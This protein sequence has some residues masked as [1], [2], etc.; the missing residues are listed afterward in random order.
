MKSSDHYKTV[1]AAAVCVV[2]ILAACAKPTASQ[3]PGDRE[4]PSDSRRNAIHPVE[5]VAQPWLGR[6][7]VYGLF[8]VPERYGGENRYQVTMSIRGVD[9]KFVIGEG[10]EKVL[11]S[12]IVIEQGYYAKQVYIPTRVALW[13]LFT[14]QFSELR[15]PC[16]WTIEFSE[17]SK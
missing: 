2:L 1:G 3:C 12:D 11:E 10:G 5:V 4:E 15:S 13:S 6:H 9:G 16:N 17:R 14:G 7:Q 8:M